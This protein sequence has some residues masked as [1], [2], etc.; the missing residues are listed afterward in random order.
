MT[1]IRH[2]ALT[3]QVEGERPAHE[4]P[5]EEQVDEKYLEQVV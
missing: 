1:G 4:Q 2:V 5:A 3:T